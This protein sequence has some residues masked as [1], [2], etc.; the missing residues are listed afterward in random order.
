MYNDIS[1]EERLKRIS[2]LVLRGIHLYNQKNQEN[3]STI[4]KNQSL[5]SSMKKI[6]GLITVANKSGKIPSS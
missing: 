1:Q 3:H 2:K 5:Y 6:D 4:L